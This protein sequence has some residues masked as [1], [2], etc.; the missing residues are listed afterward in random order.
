M[1]YVII[2]LDSELPNNSASG[3]SYYAVSF[4]IAIVYIDMVGKQNMY[5]EHVG[6]R[7]PW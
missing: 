1:F 6:L 3:V 2:S 4:P 7:H 5:V